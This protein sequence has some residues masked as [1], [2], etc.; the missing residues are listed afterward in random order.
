MNNKT[1][2]PL[3]MGYLNCHMVYLLC[4]LV[5]CFQTFHVFFPFY[6]FWV[7][8]CMLGNQEEIRDVSHILEMWRALESGPRYLCNG[9]L[10]GGSGQYILEMWR[11]LESGPRYLCNGCQVGGSGPL[12]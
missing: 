8:M 11:A 9:C 7:I 1:W 2:M 6:D 3:Y 12:S 10:V 4:L 5:V